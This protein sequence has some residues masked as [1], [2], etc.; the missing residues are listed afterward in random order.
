MDRVF[1]GGDGTAFTSQS[2]LSL[3]DFFAAMAICG[4]A[5]MDCGVN[6]ARCTEQVSDLACVAYRIA[7]A[8]LEKREQK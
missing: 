1:P 2:G 6:S 7:D 5:D 4:T 3:R 8:M